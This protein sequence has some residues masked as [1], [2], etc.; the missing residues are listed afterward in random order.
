[1]NENPVQVNW[2]H[3][4]RKHASPTIPHANVEKTKHRYNIHQSTHRRK[5][6]HTQTLTTIHIDLREFGKT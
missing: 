5:K 4:V 2:S 1:M 3:A 6:K